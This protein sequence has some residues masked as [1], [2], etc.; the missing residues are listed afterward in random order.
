MQ[1]GKWLIPFRGYNS[2]GAYNQN[3]LWNMDSIYIMD[4]HRA[5]MW[6]WFQ[7][8]DTEKRYNLFHIDRHTDTLYS[9]IETWREYMPDMQKVTL[10]DYLTLNHNMT[11]EKTR[12]IRWDNYLSLFLD[13]YSHMI[14]ECY[15]ATH[16]EGDMPRF[17]NSAV[18]RMWDI[19]LNM[20]YWINSSKEDWIFNID[21]D[22]FV[23]ARDG[24]CIELFS[25]EYIKSMFEPI[26]EAYHRGKI[27]VIT[28]S[29]SPECSGGWEKSL[30]TCNKICNLFDIEISDNENELFIIGDKGG[31][32]K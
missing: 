6:C 2:S 4:N 20:D 1:K 25:D 8:I 23:M 10:E 16:E 3:L 21:I 22:Y 29:L 18:A 11:D 14:H 26:V 5:A 28:I 7:Q 19:P 32:S 15:F 31:V 30:V 13:R 9:N 17:S 24:Y 27:S 12:L